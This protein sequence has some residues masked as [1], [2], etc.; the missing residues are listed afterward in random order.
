MQPRVLQSSNYSFSW[1]TKCFLCTETTIVDN[2]QSFS[3]QSAQLSAIRCVSTLELKETVLNHCPL[4]NDDWSL[5]VEGRLQSCFDLVA[6]EA[7]YHKTCLAN[8]PNKKNI[9]LIES[10]ILGVQRCHQ[11]CSI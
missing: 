8:F 3:V 2:R 9:G 1:K 4:R 11:V 6:E 7:V 10:Q 5:Q